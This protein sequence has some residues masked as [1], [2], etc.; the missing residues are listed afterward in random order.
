MATFGKLNS[1]RAQAKG[2]VQ[3]GVSALTD[4]L[5]R[6]VTG[7]DDVSKADTLDISELKFQLTSPDSMTLI[8]DGSLKKIDCSKNKV[9]RRDVAT[10]A[11]HCV[12]LP[13]STE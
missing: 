2:E 13:G 8:K 4:V 3:G 1:F 6:E 7:K 11:C 9:R 10:C 5:I 12:L